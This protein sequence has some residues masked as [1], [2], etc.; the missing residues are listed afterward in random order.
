MLTENEA[1]Q[2]A[3]YPRQESIEVRPLVSKGILSVQQTG[4]VRLKRSK[5]RMH[6]NNKFLFNDFFFRYSLSHGF[7]HDRNNLRL[8]D[9]PAGLCHKAFHYPQRDNHTS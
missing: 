4:I 6:R 5:I 3:L 1:L 2:D 8:L 7:P 9:A